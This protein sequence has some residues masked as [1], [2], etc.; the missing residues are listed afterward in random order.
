MFNVNPGTKLLPLFKKKKPGTDL[1]RAT[2]YSAGMMPKGFQ[3]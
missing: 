2:K 1:Q 3:H